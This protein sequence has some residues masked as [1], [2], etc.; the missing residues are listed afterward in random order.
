MGATLC[1]FATIAEGH[2]ASEVPEDFLAQAV[3]QEAEEA[4]VH[5]ADGGD[6]MKLSEEEVAQRINAAVDK[7]LHRVRSTALAH[8]AQADSTALAEAA[9][10]KK[11]IPATDKPIAEMSKQP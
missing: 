5:S 2:P 6:L 11:I 10:E 9:E 4:I 7:A 1:L 3:V 8:S